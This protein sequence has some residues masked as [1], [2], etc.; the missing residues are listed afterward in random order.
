MYITLLPNF[1]APINL[2]ADR[3]V[4]DATF[5]NKEGGLTNLTALSPTRCISSIKYYLAI[6]LVNGGLVTNFTAYKQD[7]CMNKALDFIIINK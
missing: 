5:V 4:N 7:R 2:N 1:T 6:S 3:C